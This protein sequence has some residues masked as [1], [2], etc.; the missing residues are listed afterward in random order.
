MA[1]PPR[2]KGTS[3][4]GSRPLPPWCINCGKERKMIAKIG[5]NTC[6]FGRD[7]V[8]SECCGLCPDCE[9]FSPQDRRER[10]EESKVM[11]PLSIVFLLAIWWLT[12]HC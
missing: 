9:W 7:G 4:V 6:G 5:C 3:T 10:R 1:R 12:N 2:R 8:V 11:I